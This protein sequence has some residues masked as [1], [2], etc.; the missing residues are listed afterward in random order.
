M[1]PVRSGATLPAAQHPTISGENPTDGPESGG[2]NFV[3]TG[4][5]VTHP[6]ISLQHPEWI[7]NFDTDPVMALETRKRFLDMAVQ[8]KLTLIGYHFDFPRHRQCRKGGQRLPFRAD[9][10]GGLMSA[11]TTSV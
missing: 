2:Q 7:L 10:H 9:Q 6:A 5:A 3:Y 1:T 4:D 8:D 11:A